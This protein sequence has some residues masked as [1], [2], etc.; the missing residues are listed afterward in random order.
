M[1]RLCIV[2][3]QLSLLASSSDAFS[4]SNVHM[5]ATT[6]SLSTSTFVRSSMYSAGYS[7][8]LRADASDEN[9][10]GGE[11]KEIAAPD[12][13]DILN[14]PAFLQRKLEVLQADIA[15]AEEDIE[16]AKVAYEQGK[17][18]W[19]EKLDTI[20]TERANLQERMSKQV[21]EAG[22]AATV[23]VVGKLLS[24]LDNFDRAFTSVAAETDA[25][26][27][28]EEAYKGAYAGILETFKKLG[29]NEV[30][31]VGKEFDYELHNAI[32]MRPDPDVEE[33]F[34][35]E[36]LQKGYVYGEVGTDEEGNR[37]D[38]QLIRPAMV[39]VSA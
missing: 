12:A 2:A 8:A 37:M 36:E 20:R 24:V 13:G 28:V 26:K 29:V 3:L 39:V 17:E 33:G 16:N 23:E 18:E 32:M 21:E 4:I 34:I 5:G 30:E 25:D 22:G 19:G 9:S 10:E 6:S 15:K 38:G 14:S 7:T 31:T 1:T 11:E 27:E 35:V